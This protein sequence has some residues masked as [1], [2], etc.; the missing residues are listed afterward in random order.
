[1][2][3]LAGT[4]CSLPAPPCARKNEEMRSFAMRAS[5]SRSRVVGARRS[6]RR[7]HDVADAMAIGIAVDA[8]QRALVATRPSLDR[9]THPARCCLS[10]T[11][12]GRG[13]PARPRPGCGFRPSRSLGSSARNIRAPLARR[14]A[15]NGGRRPRRRA[16]R[17]ALERVAGE[18]RRGDFG[19]QP[20]IECARARPGRPAR[21]HSRSS[22][23]RSKPTVW[24]ITTAPPMNRKAPATRR[25][26][27]GI[28]DRGGVDP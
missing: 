13:R 24:P 17:R 25:R 9:S 22:T 15:R 19:K 21:S 7:A 8:P 11:S 23:A 3:A 12:V 2:P 1:M 14:R 26:R 18:F 28:R 27:R 20:R 10:S 16:S 4:S 5:V 6:R